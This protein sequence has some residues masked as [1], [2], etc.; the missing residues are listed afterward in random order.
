MTKGGRRPLRRYLL[1]KYA[2]TP[3]AALPQRPLGLRPRPHQRAL[4]FGILPR[5]SAPWNPQY[6]AVFMG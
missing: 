5:G 4:P 1:R 6:G 2:P 3:S